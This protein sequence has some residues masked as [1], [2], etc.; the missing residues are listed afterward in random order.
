MPDWLS[1]KAPLLSR[2]LQQAGYATAHYGKWYLANDMIPDSPT[3]DQYGY[4]DYGAFNCAG[5]QMPFY[6]D[7]TRGKVHRRKSAKGKAVLYQRIHESHTPFHVL[8]RHQHRFPDLEKADQIMR[9]F[10]PTLTIGSEKS[11]MLSIG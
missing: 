4:D 10:F 1:P 5:E 3:P 11:L 7:S 8:P 9:L 6:E 2:M